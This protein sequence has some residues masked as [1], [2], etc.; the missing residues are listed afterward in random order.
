[1]SLIK[2]IYCLLILFTQSISLAYVRPALRREITPQNPIEIKF[3]DDVTEYVDRLKK[4]YY[5]K[6]DISTG[7]AKAEQLAQY[8]ELRCKYLSE[9]SRRMHNMYYNNQKIIDFI[10]KSEKNYPIFL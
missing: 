8:D 3:P 1:M 7:K 5:I 2:V 4:C 10:T 6:N 9:D